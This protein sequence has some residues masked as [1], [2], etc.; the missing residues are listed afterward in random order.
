MSISTCWATHQQC[1]IS[2]VS[3]ACS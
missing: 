1:D 3:D 2:T